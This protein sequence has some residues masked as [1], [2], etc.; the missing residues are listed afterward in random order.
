MSKADKYFGS[1]HFF[2]VLFIGVSLCLE[3]QYLVTTFFVVL[4]V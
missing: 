3:G 2:E 4:I 1:E